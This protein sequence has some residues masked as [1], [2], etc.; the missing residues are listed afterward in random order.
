[1]PSTPLQRPGGRVGIAMALGAGVV[2]LAASCAGSG[3]PVATGIPGSPTRTTATPTV[4][5]PTIATVAPTAP[6]TTPS[7]PGTWALLPRSPLSGAL[8]QRAGV[9]D[10]TRML[11]AGR[12]TLE[13]APYVRD[14]LAAYDPATDSWQQ[15]QGAPGP[16][17]NFEGGD[18]AVWDGTEMLLW[19]VTNTAYNPRTKA[20]RTLPDPPAGD[21]GPSVVVWTG[22]QMI[23]WGGGCCGD[24]D[25]DGA[26]YTPAT[27][28]WSKLPASPLSGRHTMGAWTG[29]ELL[30][31]GGEGAY[32]GKALADGAAYNPR[33]H[34]WRKLPDMPVARSWGTA[35]WDGTELLVVG[36]SGGPPSNSLLARGVAYS[37]KTNTWRWLPPMAYPRI[38]HV[39]VWTGT[40]LLVWGGTTKS[41]GQDVTPP[42]GEAYDPTSNTWAAMPKAPL[43]GRSQAIAV[44]T[45]SAMIVWGGE[46]SQGLRLDGAAYT[47][48]V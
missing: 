8:Y 2:L 15:L 10:G 39:A 17:G 34:S 28:S 21:G 43:R 4:T 46:N 6:A 5:P 25:A 19:G 44:W 31:V 16:E 33:T 11:I 26:A 27:N 40:L 32:P 12:V 20:W 9:W 42:H 45:G 36:G 7:K 41:A 29:R 22:T 14:V 13:K 35:V 30:I 24:A 23:G 38:G 37:P 18:R 48:G 1:M 47:P 3:S